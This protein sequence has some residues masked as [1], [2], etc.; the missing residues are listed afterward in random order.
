MTKE[1]DGSGFGVFRIGERLIGVPIGNLAEVC[2]VPSVS[3]LM[4]PDQSLIGAFDLRGTLVPL[5]DIE[6]LSGVPRRDRP[7]EK[8][9]VLQHDTRVAAIALDEII[10]LTDA[11]PTRTIRGEFRGEDGS[12]TENASASPFQSGFVLNGEVVSC[13]DAKKLFSRPDTMSIASTRAVKRGTGIARNRKF[14]IFRAGG[15]H[16]GIDTDHIWATV[17]RRVIDT[18]EIGQDGGT[19]LGFIH[20]HGW[21]VPVV[22][23]NE[24]LGI[25][26]AEKPS[27]TEVVVLRFADDKLLGLTV[28]ATERLSA[29][30]PDKMHES[31]ALLSRRRILKRVFVAENGEQIFI[32]DFRGLFDQPD[33]ASLANL[34]A[35]TSTRNEP[36]NTGTE[37]RNG[38]IRERVRYLVFD[39]GGKMAVRAELVSRILHMPKIIVPAR[40]VPPSVR[41]FFTVG[42]RSVPLI[43]LDGRTVEEAGE[44]YVLLVAIGDRQVGFLANRICSMQTSE[45]RIT[46][47]AVGDKGTELV[48]IRNG[49]EKTMIPVPRLLEI[50]S[51]IVGDLSPEAKTL[52]I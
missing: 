37:D 38:T 16:F 23:S 46:G 28:D 27:D 10:S 1:Q 6:A 12:A 18:K 14:L 32:I 52:A 2:V 49:E 34:T 29:I 30:A 20:H 22:Q 31:S 13:L 11:S 43:S 39:A 9:A 50:A 25:G 24:V 42:D 4:A 36:V 5:L 41:G 45:L 3:K 44:G 40:N 17:P 26:V 48:Q 19:C 7:V 33:L 8:A 51:S 15:A 21:R 35:K 47:D